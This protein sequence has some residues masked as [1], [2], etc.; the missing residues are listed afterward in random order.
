MGDYCM[1]NV[2]FTSGEGDGDRSDRK[3]SGVP[4]ASAGF[5][6]FG[7]DRQAGAEPG[8][9]LVN[10]D[11][12][13]SDMSEA[14][15]DQAGMRETLEQLHDVYAAGGNE[16]TFLRNGIDWGQAGEEEEQATG[17]AEDPKL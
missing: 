3:R 17:P 14:D 1:A 7:A 16:F 11:L 5:T 2:R 12:A 8:A 4:G 6:A 13:L 10:P 15:V 9:A